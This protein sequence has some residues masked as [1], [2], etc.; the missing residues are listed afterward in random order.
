MKRQNRKVERDTVAELVRA[1]RDL[2]RAF[3]ERALIRTDRWIHQTMAQ[4]NVKAPHGA[5]R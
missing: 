3:V 1:S 5:K 4:R 2:W